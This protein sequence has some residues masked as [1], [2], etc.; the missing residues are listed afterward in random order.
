MFKTIY[1]LIIYFNLIFFIRFFLSY[2]QLWAA[3]KVPTNVHTIQIRIQIQRIQLMYSPKETVHRRVE[4]CWTATKFKSQ[5]H[6]DIGLTT[7]LHYVDNRGHLP[8]HLPTSSCPRSL[9]M[10]PN[11]ILHVPTW[12]P[13]FYRNIVTHTSCK[14]K[15]ILV[16]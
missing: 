1:P 4:N 2:L 10:T 13:F 3:S 12:M 9:W 5:V 7:Y 8:D 16:G 6:V 11:P 15:A 14:P